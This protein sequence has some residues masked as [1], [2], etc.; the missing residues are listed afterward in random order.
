MAAHKPSLVAAPDRGWFPVI[1]FAQL[2]VDKPTGVSTLG[3][4]DLVQSMHKIYEISDGCTF[5]F[6]G[7]RRAR[8]VESG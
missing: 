3:D 1:E 6:G 5:T 8:P 2:P 4:R 7:P